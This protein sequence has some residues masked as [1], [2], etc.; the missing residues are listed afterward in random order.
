MK[1]DKNESLKHHT[2]FMGAD[3]PYWNIKWDIFKKVF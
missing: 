2:N 1:A 3:N